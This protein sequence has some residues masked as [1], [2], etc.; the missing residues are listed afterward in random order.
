MRCRR[1]REEEEAAFICVGEMGR[2]RERGREKD[3]ERETERERE[4]TVTEL[5]GGDF[6]EG[7][8]SK[9]MNVLST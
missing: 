3:K 8:R 5:Q 2:R 7:G 1:K 6:R 4:E 9:S